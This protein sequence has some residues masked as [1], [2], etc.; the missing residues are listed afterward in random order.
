MKRLGARGLRGVRGEASPDDDASFV[1]LRD[2]GN[3]P[4]NTSSRLGEDC[5]CKQCLQA[6]SLRHSTYF[7]Q[8]VKCGGNYFLNRKTT[9]LS[10]VLIIFDFKASGLPPPRPPPLWLE[11]AALDLPDRPENGPVPNGPALERRD[12]RLE[13]R[14][15]IGTRERLGRVH[16]RGDLL[17]GE[18]ERGWHYEGASYAPE[19]GDAPDRAATRKISRCNLNPI[20]TRMSGRLQPQRCRTPR[21]VALTSSVRGPWPTWPASTV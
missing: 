20:Q 11:I 8:N 12:H 3:P 7:P 17:I 6:V 18:G 9:R 5:S 16:D 15:P 14:R 19:S 4:S 10:N 1:E 21:L 13:E 2:T